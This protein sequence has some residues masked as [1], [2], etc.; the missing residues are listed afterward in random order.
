MLALESDG[1][2]TSRAADSG[3]VSERWPVESL[4]SARALADRRGATSSFAFALR[5]APSPSHAAT[6]LGK[7]LCACAGPFGVRQVVFS[8]DSK[9]QRDEI[10]EHLGALIERA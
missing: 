4:L 2:I 6:L 10:V 9:E 8:V 5:L 7:L 1:L 3:R